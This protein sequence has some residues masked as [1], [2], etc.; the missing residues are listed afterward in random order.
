MIQQLPLLFLLGLSGEPAA[1]AQ[2]LVHA[3]R[4]VAAG[5]LEEALEAYS[6]AYAGEEGSDVVAAYNAGTV[7]L[8]LGRLPEAVLWLRRAEAGAAEPDPWAAENLAA[9]RRLLGLSERETTPPGPWAWGLVLHVGSWL[10]WSGVGLAW[11][12]LGLGLAT[13]NLRI[14][15]AVLAAAALLFGAGLAWSR[16]GPREAVLLEACPG[17]PMPPGRQVWALP[18]AGPVRVWGP[19]T[20][21]LCP[22]DALGLVSEP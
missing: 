15:L 21:A 6:A 19:G 7:A 12:A 14:S 16:W 4:L 1:T 18:G 13:R 20:S 5:R 3:D 8:Q 10:V 22:A 9:A 2:A 17:L 11:T